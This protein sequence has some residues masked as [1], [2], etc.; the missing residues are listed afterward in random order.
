MLPPLAHHALPPR[1][2]AMLSHRALAPCSLTMLSRHALLPC[3]C[4]M[5]P[6][7]SPCSHQCAELRRRPPEVM[8]ASTGHL[9]QVQ[10]AVTMLAPGSPTMPSHHAIS[11][12]SPAVLSLHALT[13]CSHATLSR[14]AP[15]MCSAPSSDA[16]HPMSCM[17][18]QATFTI[19]SPCCHHAFIMPSPCSFT[20]PPPHPRHALLML[21]PCS[22]P[23]SHH[24]LT[25]LSPCSHHALAMLSHRV[26]IML[27]AC[28]CPR[29]TR[30]GA[31]SGA[32]SMSRAATATLRW[33]PPRSSQHALF[34]LPPGSHHAPHHA[35]TMLSQR[36]R[37]ASISG[38]SFDAGS[39]AEL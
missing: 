28:C 33:S 25:M 18:A 38:P 36:C 14:H 8:H 6:S 29:M 15:T 27:L 35:P 17:P 16:G 31:G 23:C 39:L 4:T 32:R 20:M 34:M 7:P 11:P 24:A 37:Y 22:F 30:G 19:L 13:P 12:C 3:S 10:G 1:F 9:P 21:S 26:L 5:L 2:L